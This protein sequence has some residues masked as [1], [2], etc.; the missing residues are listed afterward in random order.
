MTTPKLGTIALDLTCVE[1]GRSPRAGETW[2]RPPAPAA[3]IRASNS[4]TRTPGRDATPALP[5]ATPYTRTGGVIESSECRNQGGLDTP[6]LSVWTFELGAK[7]A[8]A[9]SR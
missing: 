3:G 5:G 7:L 9:S 1:C 2:V 8:A 4:E 6:A